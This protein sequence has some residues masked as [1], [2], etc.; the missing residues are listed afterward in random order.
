MK[1]TNRTNEHI[2]VN[3][4][5]FFAACDIGENA[6]QFQCVCVKEVCAFEHL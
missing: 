6:F 1:L 4:V 3:I 2:S 5:W